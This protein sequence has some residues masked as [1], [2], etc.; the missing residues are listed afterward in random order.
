MT[1]D[2]ESW[3]QLFTEYATAEVL[4]RSGN[5][6]RF[7]LTMHPDEQGRVWSWVSER[8]AD[9]ATREVVAR[10]VETG[11]FDH[12]DIRWTYEDTGRGVAM[13]W[14]QDFAMKPDAPIDTEGMTARIDANTAVQMAVIREKVEAAARASASPAG[15]LAGGTA[16]SR[17]SS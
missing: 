4:E 8:T 13:R 6:V 12:M 2:V 11:P 16:E 3:P 10:R 9:P 7:R 5:T 15:S 1:N 17:S 14:V